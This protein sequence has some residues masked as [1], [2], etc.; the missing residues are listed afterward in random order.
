MATTKFATVDEYI[1]SFQ[2]DVQ[3][4]LQKI[5]QTVK[6]AAPEA[7]EKISYQMP[8]FCT[9]DGQGLVCFSAWKR[10][11]GFYG[12]HRALEEFKE[13]LAPYVQQKGT[14][15]FP[16]DEPFPFALITEIVRSR[17]K[18]NA[19]KAKAKRAGTR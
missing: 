18:E 11:I 2:K 15:R 13:E 17:L 7:T 19:E 4:L 16:L 12:L 6:E 8:T 10:H 5:R 14:L 1:A 3:D 9:P